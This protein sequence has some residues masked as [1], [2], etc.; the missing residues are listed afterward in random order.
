M[1]SRPRSTRVCMITMSVSLSLSLSH[2]WVP[3]DD[4]ITEILMDD[5]PLEAFSD[6]RRGLPSNKRERIQAIRARLGT[7]HGSCQQQQR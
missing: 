6:Y 7:F 2:A 4:A 1:N 5:G 3:Q